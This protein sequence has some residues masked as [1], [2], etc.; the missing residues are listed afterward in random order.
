MICPRCGTKHEAEDGVCPRCFHGRPKKKIKLPIWFP[1]ALMGAFMLAVVVTSVII[2]AS[3]LAPKEPEIDDS[4]LD[5]AW[6]GKN[7][8]IKLDA[9]ANTFLL[10]ASG[11]LLQGEF[12]LEE[13]DSLRLI[14]DEGQHYLYT[15]EKIDP[16][17][18]RV[19]FADGLSLVRETLVR[20]ADE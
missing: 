18:L 10:D 12:K 5:G 3:V 11:E 15:Y 9:D 1:W 19:S 6:K 20:Q 17:T 7:M 4:W 16:N 13:P 14:D 8:T 2:V